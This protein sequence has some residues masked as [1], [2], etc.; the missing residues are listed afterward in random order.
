LEAKLPQAAHEDMGEEKHRRQ[1]VVLVD[2]D[3]VFVLVPSLL[4]EE[5]PD[6]RV[7]DPNFGG[8]GKPFTAAT[9]SVMRTGGLD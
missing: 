1:H 9:K 7:H 4:D 6:L 2:R 8:D 3:T 5:T